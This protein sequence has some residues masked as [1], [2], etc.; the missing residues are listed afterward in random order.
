MPSVGFYLQFVGRVGEQFARRAP[1]RMV[2][3]LVPVVPCCRI[4]E[5]SRTATAHAIKAVSKCIHA[6]WPS[7][8]ITHV[9]PLPFPLRGFASP[10][11]PLPADPEHHP[12]NG[13]TSMPSPTHFRVTPKIQTPRA[14]LLP[15][16]LSVD[17]PRRP[18]QPCVLTENISPCIVHDSGRRQNQ[19]ITASEEELPA[20]T[21]SMA[22][23]LKADTCTVRE[24]RPTSP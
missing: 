17:T 1:L 18:P 24:Q 20:A 9:K 10:V 23:S 3:D 5:H 7:H 19:L 14:S 4:W 16:F 22:R 21:H 11:A 2:E 13:Q 8:I 15:S 6:M 12:R